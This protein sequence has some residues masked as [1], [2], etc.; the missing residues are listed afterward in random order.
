MEK[1]EINTQ[2]LVK[3]FAKRGY[4]WEN[5]SLY[6]HAVA[7]EEYPYDK[8]VA[9]VGTMLAL[10]EFPR[11]F[12]VTSKSQQFI[13]NISNS[14]CEIVGI[15]RGN[16]T[17]AFQNTLL[18]HLG[19]SYANYLSQHY[20]QKIFDNE[21]QTTKKI[22]E[23]DKQ[24]AKLQAEKTAIKQKSATLEQYYTKR[25]Q[26]AD[27]YTSSKGLAAKKVIENKDDILT[28]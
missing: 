4:T 10:T 1:F 26:H 22:S 11:Q 21:D 3:F 24:I 9:I 18:K 8:K 28:K 12:I 5:K 17:E 20:E 27:N 2:L 23:I 15:K 25:M 16:F 19:T 7:I 6:K 13:V 14:Q